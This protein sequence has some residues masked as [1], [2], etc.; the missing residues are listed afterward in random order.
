[1]SIKSRREI[2]CYVGIYYSSVFTWILR[3]ML[4]NGEFEFS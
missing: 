4:Q 2:V 3:Q 1:M